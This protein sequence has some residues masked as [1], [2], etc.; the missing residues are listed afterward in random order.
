ML[1]PFKDIFHKG[2]INNEFKVWLTF[3]YGCIDVII[4]CTY[5]RIWFKKKNTGCK[6]KKAKK[7]TQ[8]SAQRV[9]MLNSKRAES[10]QAVWQGIRPSSHPFQSK[11]DWSFYAS[12]FFRH[13]CV[14]VSKCVGVHLLADA[15]H[16]YTVFMFKP[17]HDL[18]K[19]HEFQPFF[20]PFKYN[21][22][23]HRNEWEFYNYSMYYWKCRVCLPAATFSVI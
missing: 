16:T 17:Q 15:W 23:T 19:Y 11:S 12:V 20:F 9:S 21:W 18:W 7:F 6:T 13:S 4:I 10:G 2:R 5:I 14:S 22:E 8:K 1:K 3:F